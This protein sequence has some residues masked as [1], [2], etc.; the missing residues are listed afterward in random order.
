MVRPYLL[1]WHPYLCTCI[2]DDILVYYK[3]TLACSSVM[4]TIA[5]SGCVKQAAGMALWLTTWGRPRMFSTAEM[6]W[7]DA[8]CANINLPGLGR[9]R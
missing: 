2:H 5:I 7:A 1:D 8:A 3:R 9:K 6:P 4:P